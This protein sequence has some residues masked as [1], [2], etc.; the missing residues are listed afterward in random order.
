MLPVSIRFLEKLIIHLKSKPVSIDS[1]AEAVKIL[2]KSVSANSKA[3]AVKRYRRIR[4]TSVHKSIEEET[5]RGGRS[6]CHEALMKKWTKS[7]QEDVG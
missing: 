5:T 3:E 7:E 1:K 6:I 4:S 2:C